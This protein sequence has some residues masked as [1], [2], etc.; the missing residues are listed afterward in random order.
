MS[1]G[2][3]GDGKSD[4]HVWAVRCLP[5]GDIV[6]GDS[7]GQLRIWDTNNYS[8]VQS[9]Q[10]HKADILDLVVSANVQMIITGGADQRTAAY[11][12]WTWRPITFRRRISAARMRRSLR[13]TQ[14]SSF[15]TSCAASAVTRRYRLSGAAVSSDQPGKKEEDDES[16]F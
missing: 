11:R 6:S 9:I 14:R 4:V 1:L 10:A 15:W 5:N 13:S 8:L 12:F 3:P 16:E 7:T 2:K